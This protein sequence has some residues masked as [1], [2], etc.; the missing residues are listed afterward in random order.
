MRTHLFG[1]EQG[2]P[3]FRLTHEV[4]NVISDLKPTLGTQIADQRSKVLSDLFLCHVRAP[5]PEDG[6]L[7]PH[8]IVLNLTQLGL[9][10]RHIT[11]GIRLRKMNRVSQPIFFSDF[12]PHVPDIV[13]DAISRDTPL[14]KS[15]GGL[16]FE[17][18]GVCAYVRGLYV[19][20]AFGRKVIR[21]YRLGRLNMTEGQMRIGEFFT[22]E[23]KDFFSTLVKTEQRGLPVLD[24]RGLPT[25]RD[26]R[27]LRP[28]NEANMGFFREEEFPHSHLSGRTE[29]R[30]VLNE[31]LADFV[32]A[33]V[34]KSD[35]PISF[36]EVFAM[37]PDRA[38][39]LF[40]SKFRAE[41]KKYA[42]LFVRLGWARNGREGRETFDFTVPGEKVFQKFVALDEEYWRKKAEEA[43]KGLPSTELSL[44][45]LT[46]DDFDLFSA[47]EDED[48]FFDIL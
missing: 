14:S 36:E 31:Q 24:V 27:A 12:L 44:D 48:G 26:K 35:E 28:F 38:R 7:G 17:S 5:R 43:R 33:A 42:G 1:I 8:E 25:F 37:L 34:L 39:V 9:A 18:V 45:E 10:V 20:S 29:W 46:E 23:V 21:D 6:H 47:K 13:V 11:K 4:V 16:F 41:D 30:Y 40:L 19:P 22:P 32:R 3:Y 15:E 2:R